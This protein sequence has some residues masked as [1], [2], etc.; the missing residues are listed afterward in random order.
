LINVA[1]GCDMVDIGYAH[2]VL[3]TFSQLSVRIP[4]GH[5]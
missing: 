5:R 3:S 4:P 2:T 1:I